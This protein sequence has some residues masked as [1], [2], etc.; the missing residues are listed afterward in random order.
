MLGLRQISDEIENLA[1]ATNVPQ[2]KV[3]ELFL[4]LNKIE[5]GLGPIDSRLLAGPVDLISIALG[6]VQELSTALDQSKGGEK[7]R[8]EIRNVNQAIDAAQ[9]G[10]GG[11]GGQMGV[12]AG[13]MQVT[14]D[15][16]ERFASAMERAATASRNISVPTPQTALER[17]QGGLAFLANGGHGLDT[18]PAMLSKGEFVMNPKSTQ[19]FFSQIQAM[20]AGNQPVFRSDGG[21]TTVG[22]TSVTFNI[23][24]AESPSATA[25]AVRRQMQRIDRERRRGTGR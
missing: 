24:G 5:G 1:T 11:L 18:I 14:A 6:K 21:T 12:T 17:A 8:T 3:R 23:N 9:F 22:D 4:E 20:N 15:N 10:A 7:L 2:E 16:T 19:R 25:S 13:A